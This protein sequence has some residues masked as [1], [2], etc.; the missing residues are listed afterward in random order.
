MPTLRPFSTVA[1]LLLLSGLVAALP[2]SALAAD[3]PPVRPVLAPADF[4]VADHVGKVLIVDFWAS[5]CKPC[6][7]SLPWL[8]QLVAAHG[9]EGLTVVAVNLD[10][11]FAK[12]QKLLA[13]LDPAIAVVH[14]PEGVL[15]E[16]YELQGMP[17]A[18]V[19]DRQGELRARHVGFLPA[20]AAGKE[21]EI[22]DLLH[23]G[24]AS[25]AR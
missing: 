9:A 20:E 23:E 17:S 2:A 19:Y 3:P 8:S 22:L 1:A 5:W 25:D 21:A 10:E 24:G 7:K 13:E 6:G 11:D 12:A 15:A 16:R 14:D 4:A 18:Y